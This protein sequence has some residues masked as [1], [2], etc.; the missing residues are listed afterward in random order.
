M[1][2]DSVVT[3]SGTGI[4]G[5]AYTTAISND[6][7]TSEDFLK[8]ML[9]EMKQQD[10]T[11][12]MDSSALMDSQLKMSTI[13]SNMAMAE[14]MK[15]LQQAYASSALATAANLINKVVENGTTNDSGEIKSFLVETIENKDGELYVNAREITGIKDA[16]VNKD[17]EL[18][19][20]YDAD[21]FIYEDGVKTENRLALNADG[22][23]TYNDDGTLKIVDKDNNVVTDEA[24]TSKYA[25]YGSSAIY[26][27]EST[28]IPLGSILVV[29]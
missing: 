11:K 27:D 5:N 10:P 2:V 1:A 14:S 8:L 20:I 21:G 28:V 24:I 26:A 25:Y 29:N 22:R 13:E 23:F 6:Q 19:T 12:P 4:D 16:L 9:E 7:L 15:T 17:T 18:L 3:K